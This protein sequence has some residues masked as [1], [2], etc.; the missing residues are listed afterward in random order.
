M[1]KFVLPLIICLLPFGLTGQENEIKLMYSPVSLQRIDD[2]GRNLDGLTGSYS[3]AF[4]IDYN[5]YLKPRLKLGVNLTYQQEKVEGTKT[6]VFRNPIPPY[7]LITTTYEQK[8]KERWLFIGPQLG[9]EYIQKERF[10]MGSLIGLSMVVIRREDT[11]DSRIMNDETDINLFFPAEL[12][13][14]SWGNSSGLTGQLGFGHKGLVS[15]G[16]FIRW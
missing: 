7:E 1:H 2:W 6:G 13:N 5:L 8:N 4:I 10:R 9:F 14:F 16:Y 3:G 12:V 15:L 11:V